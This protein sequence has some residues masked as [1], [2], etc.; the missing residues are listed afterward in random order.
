MSTGG[1]A[2]MLNGAAVSWASKLQPTVT[3]STTEAE[4]MAAACAVKEALWLAKLLATF[5][6]HV[7]PISIWCDSQ[8]AMHLI[9]NAVIS[10]RSK[11]IDVQ[12]HF[13][14]ERVARKEVLFDYCSTNAN[15]A[16]CLTKALP[17]AKFSVLLAGLGLSKA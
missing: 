14:K 2:F 9:K 7:R 13:L 12:H 8:S 6:L 15:V 10:Q 3:L 4:Y 5:G 16:D 17:W 1:F 11:H